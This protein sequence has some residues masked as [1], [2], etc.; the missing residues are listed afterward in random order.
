MAV[1]DYTNGY[2]TD[3]FDVLKEQN[4]ELPANAN[5]NYDCPP[6]MKKFKCA[7]TFIE[8]KALNLYQLDMIKAIKFVANIGSVLDI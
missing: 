3:I 7:Q 1:S 4:N 6:N 5:L 2:I 8:E